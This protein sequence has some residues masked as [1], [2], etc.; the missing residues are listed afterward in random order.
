MSEKLLPGSLYHPPA[1][2][3]HSGSSL[4]AVLCGKVLGSPRITQR[5]LYANVL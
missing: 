3:F 1:S 2:V 4:P 5:R